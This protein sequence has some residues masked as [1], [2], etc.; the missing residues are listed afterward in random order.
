MNDGADGAEL[1][2]D[3]ADQ[4]LDMRRIGEVGGE[5]VARGMVASGLWRS[6]RARSPLRFSSSASAEAMPVSSSVIRQT[7]PG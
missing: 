2:T 1:L 4:R 5:Y 7:R 3:G 6:S